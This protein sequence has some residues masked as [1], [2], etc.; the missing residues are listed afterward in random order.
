MKIIHQVKDRTAEKEIGGSAPLGFFISNRKCGAFLFDASKDSMQFYACSRQSGGQSSPSKIIRNIEFPGRLKEVRNS[1]HSIFMKREAEDR[2]NGHEIFVPYYMDALLIS[3]ESPVPIHLNLDMKWL[4]VTEQAGRAVLSMK[5]SQGNLLFMAVQGKD[6]KYSFKESCKGSPGS[7]LL[8]SLMSERISISVSS[9]QQN[10]IATANHLFEN[11][12]P[13]RDM[14]S[15]YLTTDSDFRDAETALAYS[16][17]MNCLDQVFITDNPVQ[18]ASARPAESSS[19]GSSEVS[20]EGSSEGSSVDLSASPAVST[21]PVFAEV[22]SPYTAIAM[23]AMVGEGEFQT[24]KNLLFREFNQQS[25]A[26]MHDSFTLEAVAWPALVLGKLLNR[27]STYDKLLHYFS[28]HEISMI[29]S[30]MDL[31][32]NDVN[33]RYLKSGYVVNEDGCRNLESQAMMLSM[34][35]LAQALKPSQEHDAAETLLRYNAKKLLESIMENEKISPE[36]IRSIFLTA[37]IYPQLMKQERWRPIFDRLLE[38]LH[39]DF[40]TLRVKRVGPGFK[41]LDIF[42]LASLAAIVMHK[43]DEEHYEGQVNKILRSN[44]TDALYKGLIGRPTS[45]F[46]QSFS[47]DASPIIKNEHLLNNTLFLEMLRTVLL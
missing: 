21:L 22:T 17:V 29:S 47:P 9:D 44:V 25:A 6:L 10:A 31:I 18:D 38:Q 45:A 28:T 8:L 30:E 1:I 39:N 3:T 19:A 32:I 20:S 43:T 14:Q 41:S 5:D 34:Y 26:V 12:T 42:G 24:A 7:N 37:Y 16:C 27:L 35:D 4:E 13:I 40:R 2:V 46:D 15:A 36:D 23:H 11:A 33:R